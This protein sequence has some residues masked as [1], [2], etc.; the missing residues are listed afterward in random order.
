MTHQ[1][2]GLSNASSEHSDTEEDE[3]S[4]TKANGGLNSKRKLLF[5]CFP[6]RLENS[7]RTFLLRFSGSYKKENKNKLVDIFHP[8]MIYLESH[9]Q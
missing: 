9:F 4:S 6:T 7:V 2:K 8:F 1:L 5:L 3:Q